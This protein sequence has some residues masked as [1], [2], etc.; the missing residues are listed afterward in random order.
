M[1]GVS[2]DLL[3][4]PTMSFSTLTRRLPLTPLWPLWRTLG[5]PAGYTLSKGL[6]AQARLSCGTLCVPTTEQ[7]GRLLFVW[8]PLA[9]LPCCCQEAIL[10]TQDS[11]FP[12]QTVTV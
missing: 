2:L 12:P 6:Q 1:T 5:L 11:R 9:L 7:R 4:P 8:L 3:L 10:P